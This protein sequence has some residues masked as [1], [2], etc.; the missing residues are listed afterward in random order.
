MHDWWYK[1]STNG[2]WQ[3]S[4]IQ[5]YSSLRFGL[6]LG[7]SVTSQKR[8]REQ[9]SLTKKDEKRY[10]NWSMTRDNTWQITFLSVFFSRSTIPDVKTWP[11][12]GRGLNSRRY[13]RPFASLPTGHTP[14]RYVL[15]RFFIDPSVRK[16]GLYLMHKQRA[17]HKCTKSTRAVHLVHKI[18]S[19]E[20][21]VRHV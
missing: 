18:R 6:C 1:D 19:L 2:L 4:S 8:Y 16:M 21:Y 3:F 17:V 15:R 5:F 12:A 11:G 10:S 13:E 9:R 20:K 7:Y 14:V